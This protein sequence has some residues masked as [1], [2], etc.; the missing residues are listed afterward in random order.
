VAHID[1]ADALIDAAVVDVDDM[2]T[3]ERENGVDTLVL[4]GLC[5]QVT[6]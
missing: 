3:A 6:A 5:D 1:D 2:A 4:E